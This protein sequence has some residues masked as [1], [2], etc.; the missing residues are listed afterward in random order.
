M[1]NIIKQLPDSV[2]NQIAAGEV[3]QRPASAVKEMLE[4]AVDSGANDIKVIVKDSGKTLIQ[5]IDNGS[6]MTPMDARMCFERHATSKISKAED[7]FAIRTMG[8][9]GE[10]MASIAAIAQ[11]D[12][13]T[14]P[15]DHDL[16]SCLKIE[17]SKVISQES[18]QC[19]VGTNIAVKNLFYNV[20]ARR[21]FLKSNTTETRH[22]IEE[23]IRVSVINPEIAFSML[24][25]DKIV[26]KLHA[27]SLKSR[28]VGV[29]GKVYN[30]R[31]LRVEQETGQVK[32]SGFI[33]KPEFAKKTRGEQYFFVNN[34]FIK[35]A[36]L[37]HAVAN[38]FTELIPS[39]A[40]P[41]YFINIEVDPQEI[42][43]NIHPT[44]TE[45]NFKDARLVYAIL[46]AAVKQSIGK[47]SLTPTIDFDV[48]PAV[49]AA[50]NVLPRKDLKQPGVTL[51][52]D[53]NPF[54][55][56]SAAGFGSHRAPVP[57]D[58]QK[59][60][61][62]HPVSQK[63]ETDEQFDQK[64]S[65][66]SLLETEHASPFFQ[67]HQKYILTN[68]KTGM[69]VIDQQK[70]HERI[71]YEEV[72]EQLSGNTPASQQQLFPQTIHFSP[73]DAE[74]IRSLKNE[75]EKLG[76]LMDTFGAN[77]FVIKGVPSGLKETDVAALLEKIVQNHKEQAKDIKS[78]KNIIL[79]RAMA[80]NHSVK[81]GIKLEE[82]EM[83]DIFQRLF[84]CKVPQLS[85]DGKNILAIIS[86][87]EIEKFLK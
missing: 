12:M 46:R 83:A 19:A 79:A 85:P 53:Y 58:W 33:G 47:Y 26:F 41:S 64:E 80:A 3:I 1:S 25:N 73:D 44:K 43:I 23:F 65:D 18:C 68:V 2:A 62:E 34:R 29:F 57:Q 28:I 56:S 63:L 40:F 36:Y 10:A 70:A 11:V 20:P 74:I 61:T 71:L 30:E 5:I 81:A 7:L 52:P 86:L 9:R 66:S 60:Y 45:V 16:G 55:Q 13:K 42:D 14:R 69:M 51:D 38:A 50:F 4:N 8:F 32:I 78:D 21:N 72:L 67:L 76:F 37:N 39:D 31:M 48:D 87:D 54:K 82:R 15:H 22:I 35:H 24:H 17:G 49:E 6:G 84:S 59:L 27:G 75:I 77:S